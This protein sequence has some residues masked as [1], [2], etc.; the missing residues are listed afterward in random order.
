MNDP[1][2]AVAL[3]IF[4]RYHHIAEFDKIYIGPFFKKKFPKKTYQTQRQFVRKSPEGLFFFA[5]RMSFYRC[6]GF[7]EF[8]Y[9]V[10]CKP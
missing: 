10:A 2:F 4:M 7:A 3:F 9:T 1:F 6:A 5:H 8:V